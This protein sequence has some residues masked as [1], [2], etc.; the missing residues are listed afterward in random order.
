MTEQMTL[1]PLHRLGPREISPGVVTFSIPMP[2]LSADSGYRMWVKIIH[3][4][5]QFLQDIPPERF[6]MTHGEDVE[7]GDIWWAEVDIG[8]RPR[9][10][11]TSRWGEP[12]KYVYR[13]LLEHPDVAGDVDWIIDPFARE[14]GVGKLSAITIGYVPHQWSETEAEWRVPILSDLVLYELMISEFGGD[15]DR[16][17]ARLD[18]LA[19]LGVNGI[20]V[21]PVSNTANTVDWGFLPIGYF[22]VDERFG[23]RKDLQRFIDAAHQRGIAVILDAVYGHT[24]E[25]FPYS[26]LYRRLGFND[27]PFMGLFAKND[28]GES[29]DFRQA[30]TRN[31]FFTVNHHWLDCYHIDGFRYDCVPNYWDGPM[32]QG[33]AALVYHTFRHVTSKMAEGGY[34]RRFAG[35]EGIRLIQCAEHLEAPREILETSYST[36]TWQNETLEAARRV[37]LGN[38]ADLESLGL[39]F[40]LFQY[41]SKV[42]FNEESLHKSALQYIENHDHSRFVCN[43]GTL[44]RDHGGLLNEGDRRLWFKTQ[45]YLIGLLTAKGIPM[46]WQG[47]EF[48]ENYAVPEH[49]WGRILMFRPVRWDYF[50]DPIGKNIISLVR[51]LIRIRRNRIQ[52]RRGEHYFYNHFNRYQSKGVMLFARCWEEQFSLVA[53]NF[54]DQDQRVSF[55]F[56][57][58]GDYIEDLHGDD[59]LANIAQNQ[60]VWLTIP[61]NYGRIWTIAKE[62]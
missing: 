4:H 59:N 30:F 38:P 40:G 58:A 16:T 25:S 35:N 61:S 34:W 54:G 12:G 5:D 44:N 20:E 19:D 32:G 10:K 52:M 13:Y 31:F 28:F 22:G 7:Y 62:A 55:S 3:E 60:V 46:L 1:L 45:P 42:T 6:E 41:P 17:I 39:R 47:Q 29:T 9:A 37:T 53:L 23:S 18:Y 57:F 24:S 11:A 21:M 43:F 49:G 36:C 48:A 26:Y 33:Y 56:P 14:F 15:I 8:A 50:Y 2:W 27:N 51:K